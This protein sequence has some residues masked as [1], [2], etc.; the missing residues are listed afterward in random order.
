MKDGIDQRSAVALMAI[1]VSL[2][3]CTAHGSITSTATDG[4]TPEVSELATHC[5]GGTTCP[6]DGN[7][8]GIYVSDTGSYCLW[9]YPASNLRFCPESF[10]NQPAR[11][12][13]VS[14]VRLKGR[15]WS[16]AEDTVV[17]STPIQVRYDGDKQGSL[18]KVEPSTVPGT[19]RLGFTYLLEG[20]VNPAH[21]VGS[22]LPK[23][24]LLFRVDTPDAYTLELTFTE[25]ALAGAPNPDRPDTQLKLFRYRARYDNTRRNISGYYCS[26]PGDAQATPEGEKTPLS[27]S[28]LPAHQVNGATGV[29][30]TSASSVT[31]ACVSGAI[32][33][34]MENWGYVPWNPTLEANGNPTLLLGACIQGKRAAYFA[35]PKTHP[36]Q[37]FNSYTVEGTDIRIR[38]NVINFG[39]LS[40]EQGNIEAI[41]NTTGAVCFNPTNQRRP[42]LFNLEYWNQEALP[43]LPACTAQDIQPHRIITGKAAP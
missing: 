11:G 18:L 35:H 40:I 41:W 2:V 1:L 7:G 10:E 32:V 27:L 8:P 37:D 5:P 13:G 30:N 34:C 14:S 39:K 23:L 42:D 25:V 28:V 19:S 9:L 3:G 4:G 20:A 33:T 29:I 17:L 38:D 43:L 36:Y 21:V 22:T 24:M 15:L 12:D 26:E 31:M 6:G 16:G